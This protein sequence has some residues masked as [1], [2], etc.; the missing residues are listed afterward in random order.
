M[1]VWLAEDI[2]WCNDWVDMSVARWKIDKI[3]R[4]M[5]FL[6]MKLL[7]NI[8]TDHPTLAQ[9]YMIMDMESDKEINQSWCGPQFPWYGSLELEQSPVSHTHLQLFPQYQPNYEHVVENAEEFHASRVILALPWIHSI[10]RQWTD[11]DDIRNLSSNYCKVYWLE[12]RK[13][14]DP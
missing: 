11:Q 8:K 7:H 5:N 13:Y 3:F 6:S 9:V 10:H 14:F 2:F 12:L 4:K 1:C